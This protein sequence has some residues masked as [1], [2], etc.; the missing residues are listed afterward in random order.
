M[1][2]I[3]PS[4]EGEASAELNGKALTWINGQ[5]GDAEAQMAFPVYR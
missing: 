5:N 2:Q 1:L 4:N 3:L